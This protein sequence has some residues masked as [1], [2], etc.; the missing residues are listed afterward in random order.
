MKMLPMHLNKRAQYKRL[1]FDYS[2][3]REDA[4]GLSRE[5]VLRIPNVS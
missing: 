2:A 5:N 4:G 3:P 1:F